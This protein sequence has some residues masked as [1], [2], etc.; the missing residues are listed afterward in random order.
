MNDQVKKKRFLSPKA[1]I[2]RLKRHPI[3]NKKECK[4]KIKASKNP[5]Q[6]DGV[7]TQKKVNYAK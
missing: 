3:K 5:A 2:T 7:V 6:K 1:D 4:E